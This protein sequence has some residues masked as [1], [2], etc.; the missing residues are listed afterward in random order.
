[1]RIELS[2]EELKDV[3]GGA[4]SLGLIGALITGGAFVIGIIDGF[5]RPYGCRR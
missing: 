2:K 1:M 5:F 4:I 3:K